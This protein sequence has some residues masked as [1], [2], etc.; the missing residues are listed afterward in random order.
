MWPS[1]WEIIVLFAHKKIRQFRNLK[2]KRK[3]FFKKSISLLPNIFTI[4][5]AFFGFCSIIFASKSDFMPAAYFILLGALMDSIDGRLA[6]FIGVS[7][8]IGLQLDSLADSISFCLAPALL[9]YFWQ[10]KSLGFLG[11]I[12]SAIFFITGILRLARFN[13]ISHEQSLF[14]LGLPTTIAGCFLVAFYLNMNDKIDIY[15][16]PIVLILS[17]ILSFLMV[18][19]IKFPAFKQNFLK[20]YK[21]WYK[22]LLLTIFAVSFVMQFH[23]TLILLFFFYFISAIYF[24]FKLNLTTKI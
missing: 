14:F 6:R 7:S 12:I 13:V 4:A 22:F 5:N 21:K 2:S 9:I 18:S 16:L 24:N 10:L 23:G 3:L 17:L 11:L 15:M 1:N 8:E 19:K 20:P